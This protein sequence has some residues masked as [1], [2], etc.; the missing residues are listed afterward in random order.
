M[1][2]ATRI[3]AVVPLQC[4]DQIRVA[5][6]RH[7]LEQGVVLRVDI[8]ITEYDGKRCAGRMTLICTADNHRL[9][10]LDARGRALRTALPPQDILLEI[11]LGQFKAGR[12]AV[13]HHTYELAMRLTENRN[14]EFSTYRIHVFKL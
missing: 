4:G 5:R 11:L 6:T 13:H 10:V 7:G 1:A 8:R 2:A 3:L 14:S 12:Y 9:V